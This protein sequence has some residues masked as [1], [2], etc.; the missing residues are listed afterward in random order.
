MVMGVGIYVYV[1]DVNFV[2][3]GNVILG[4][5]VEKGMENSFLYVI[6]LIVEIG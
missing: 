2:K 5:V 1:E 4:Y 6:I 3:E